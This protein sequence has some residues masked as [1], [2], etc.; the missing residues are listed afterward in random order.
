MK[1][2][3][4]KYLDPASRLG[5]ILFGLIMVLTVTLSAGL[6]AD[7]GRAGVRQLLAAAI[8]CN[9]A[10]GI[11]DA[12]MYMMNCITER[13]GKVR[14]IEAVQRALDAR[15][16]LDI[17]QN[18][19]E[20]ELQSLLDPEEREAFSRSILNH[21]AK[22]RIA[23]PGV[24]KDDLYGALACFVLVFVSCLPAAIPFFIFSQPHFAL[25]VSNFLL[26]VLLFLVGQKWAQYAGTDRRIA[27]TAMVIYWPCARRCRDPARRLRMNLQGAILAAALAS[28]V[29]VSLGGTQTDVP[30]KV[31]DET[32][33]S[34]WECSLSTS[35]Y[36]VQNGRDYANPNLVVDRD[37]LHLE[38]RYNYEAIKTGS[39]W[40][41]YNFSVGKKLVLEAA[42]CSAACSE[43][44]PES[45]QA[46]RSR[47]VTSQS[48]SSLKA[49]ISS[50]LETRSGN[51]FYSWSELS[52]CTCN[53]VSCRN[54]NRP[55]QSVG[56]QLRGPTRPAG[57]IQ[58]QKD[59]FYDLLA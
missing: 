33:E 11:I 12:V 34:E 31:A 6:T 28:V 54:S 41:G 15:A 43:T 10:W 14:L 29:S 39:L 20:P 38:A 53:L 30:L 17:I 37:W 27:G 40:L 57:R 22:A 5:E 16:A 35:T 47:S 58:V 9:L 55:N 50:M 56:E 48:S 24:T 8:G 7:E 52:C 46:I 23:R 45:P 44:S 21:V 26:I 2:F 25:R 51:F 49:S 1:R 3:V 18:E 42:P 19:V 36:L 32:A 59:R 4:P 13:S